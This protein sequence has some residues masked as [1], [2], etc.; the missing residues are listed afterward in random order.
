MDVTGMNIDRFH[1]Y[2]TNPE[3]RAKRVVESL[4]IVYKCHYPTYSMKTARNCKQSPFHS[5]FEAQGA[6]FRDVSGWEAPD[7]FAGEGQVPDPGEY[8]WGR[9]TW[10][11]HWQEEHAACRNGVVVMDMSFM[12]KFMV[13]GRD[14]G[15]ALNRLSTANVDGEAGMITY[16]QFLNGSGKMEADVT[17]VKMEENKFMVVATDTAHRHV[18]TWIERHSEDLNAVVT[19]VTGAWSQLNVQGPLSR[20]L[21][22]QVTTA[23]MSNEAFPF[24]AV[25]NIDIGFARAFCN[26][27]TY[28][29]ELGYELVIPTEQ[30]L[31][32]YDRLVEAGK[33]LGLRHAGLKALS[34]L[35]ME[36]GYRDYGHDM[37]NTDTLLEVGFSCPTWTLA[38]NPLV[39]RLLTS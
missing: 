36:K 9:H 29:G 1:R 2:Q 11:P 25:R 38:S 4:G 24:R 34:S 14:A 37:D 23:D 12:S 20:E 8:S 26:R 16:T 27:I 7:W 30:A 32:V 28:L 31:H 6:H 35:R 13:Q 5:R 15:R 3:Y 39:V 21:M 19:D 10:F 18:E 17:V 22:S 33:P